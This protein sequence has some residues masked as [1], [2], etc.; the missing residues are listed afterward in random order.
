MTGGSLAEAMRM[1]MSL[2]QRRAVE[3]AIDTARG[4]AYLH[5]R[6][7]GSVIHRDLKPGNLMMAGSQYE[8]RCAPR[9]AP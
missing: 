1:Q 2:T 8:A 9:E 3:I 4:L 5:S 7:Q 6:R